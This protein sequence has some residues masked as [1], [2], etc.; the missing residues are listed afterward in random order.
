MIAPLVPHSILEFLCR[1]RRTPRAPKGTV[2]LGKGKG[3]V[4]GHSADTVAGCDIR[5]IWAST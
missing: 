5:A 4:T 3:S 2:R 1:V